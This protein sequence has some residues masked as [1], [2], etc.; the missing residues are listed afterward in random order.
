MKPM[1]NAT[2]DKK[3]HTVRILQFGEGNFLRAFFDWMIDVANSQGITDSSIAIVSPRFRANETIENLRKQDG[4]YHVC[5]EGIENGQPKQET[6]LI[7]SVAEAFSPLENEERYLSYITSPDLRFIISNT[8]EAGIRYEKDDA[9][10]LSAATFPGKITALLY[11]RYHHFDGDPAR[12]IIF[13]CCE[14]IE[15]NGQLLR[16]YVM[17]HAR[18]CKLGN[19]FIKWVEENCIFCDTLVDRIVSGYPTDSAKEINRLTGYDDR[20]LVK[21]ELYHLWVIG[22]DGVEKV[23]SELPLHKAGLNVHF[24]KSVKSFRDK[25]VRVLNG[26]HTGMVPIALQLGCE[27]VRDAF[28]NKNVNAFINQMVEREVLPVIDETPE[29]L[30][31]FSDSILERFYNPY[32]R[33]MLRSISLNSLSKWEARNFPTVRD[34]YEKKNGLADYELFTFAA[35]LALY[36]PD[37]GFIPDD[38]QGHIR[39]IHQNW[40]AD[41]AHATVSKI[42]KGGIFINDFEKIVPGFCNRVAEHLISIRKNG[43]AKALDN[44]LATR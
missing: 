8:T 7:T 41:D 21:G 40:N 6:R 13:L 29:E 17:K 22:G 24:Q 26:S 9:T 36:A 23:M 14:L 4:L 37:S 31:R 19:D 20:L 16:E 1:N 5:L 44:F 18:E 27:T 10:Q 25:K 11:H 3:Q 28:E 43:M 38:N 12:G 30:K 35:L 2:A 39:L 15:D 42:V 32:I 34:M 33:H